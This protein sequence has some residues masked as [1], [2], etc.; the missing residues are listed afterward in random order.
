MKPARVLAGVSVVASAGCLWLFP[1]QKD[2]GTGSSGPPDG[3]IDSAGADGSSG[4]PEHGAE[5]DAGECTMNS[6]CVRQ[7]VRQD[8]TVCRAHSRLALRSPECLLVRGKWDD[9]NAFTFGA[10][11]TEPDLAAPQLSQPIYN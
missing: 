4:G 9:K 11:A 10:Y 6:D 5:S 8:F 7:G 1:I 3:S 2:E